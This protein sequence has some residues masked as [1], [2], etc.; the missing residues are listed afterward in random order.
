MFSSLVEILMEVVVLKVKLK[1]IDIEVKISVDLE[2]IK[3]L[4]WNSMS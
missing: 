1:F 2:K 4:N 3:M